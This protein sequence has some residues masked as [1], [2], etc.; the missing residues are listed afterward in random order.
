[1]I[2]IFVKLFSIIGDI[3]F[4]CLLFWLWPM[5]LA[6]DYVDSN[7]YNLSDEEELSIVVGAWIFGAVWIA[8]LIYLIA[9]GIHY[10]VRMEIL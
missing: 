1:M 6:H 4:Y 3:I 8:F 10:L 5:F 9:I 2:K 7:S